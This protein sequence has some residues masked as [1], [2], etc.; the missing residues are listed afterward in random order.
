VRISL[1]RARVTTMWVSSGVATTSAGTSA[2]D[3]W[4]APAACW[5]ARTTPASALTVQSRL[6]GSIGVTN[7]APVIG[8]LGF[9][10]P[11]V[12]DQPA[13]GQ[14]PRRLGGCRGLRLDP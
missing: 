12:R 1:A 4:R 11:P 9:P 5:W 2:G 13:F 6:L 10:G 8:G 7:W 14:V 3:W